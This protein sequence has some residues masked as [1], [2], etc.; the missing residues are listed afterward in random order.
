MYSNFDVNITIPNKAVEE[1]SKRGVI[2]ECPSKNG[3][4][5]NKI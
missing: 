1:L 5:F 4:S 3:V 2:V